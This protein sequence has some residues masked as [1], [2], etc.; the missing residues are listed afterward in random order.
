MKMNTVLIFLALVAVC[1]SG[2]TVNPCTLPIDTG[3]CYAYLP[4]WG[5]DRQSGRCIQF[6]YGGC[7]GNYNRFEDE[8]TCRRICQRLTKDVISWDAEEVN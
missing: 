3:R 6:P 2:V 1:V 4:K 8:W 5:Y 7:G